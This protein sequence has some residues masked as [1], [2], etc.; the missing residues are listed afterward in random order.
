MTILYF[1]VL[2]RFEVSITAYCTVLV[3]PITAFSV[4]N[5]TGKAHYCSVLIWQKLDFPVLVHRLAPKFCRL[6]PRFQRLAPKF[7]KLAIRFHWLAL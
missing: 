2:D 3:K 6:A 7:Y 5:P 1:T 4:L